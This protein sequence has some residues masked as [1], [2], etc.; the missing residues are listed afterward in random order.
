MLQLI[1]EL[2]IVVRL[3]LDLGH[4]LAIAQIDKNNAA[5]VADR[6][7]PAEERHSRAEV[8]GGKLGTVMRAMHGNVY[9]R[10]TAN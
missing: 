7:H 6:V 8:G 4:T 3:E 10:K 5:L 1:A 9:R 2:R